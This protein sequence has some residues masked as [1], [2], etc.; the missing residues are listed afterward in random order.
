MNTTVMHSA[1][2]C[3]LPTV[4]LACSRSFCP[5]SRASRAFV[6]D[7]R[8][9]GY[10]HHEQLHRNAKPSA[11]SRSFAA[12]SHASQIGRVHNIVRSL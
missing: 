3:A 8:T 1:I 12:V 11:Q 5:S 9:D 2:N 7:A 10:R 6:P 4:R